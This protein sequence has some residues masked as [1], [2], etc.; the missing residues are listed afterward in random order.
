MKKIAAALAVLACVTLG[1]DATAPSGAPQP[2][3][4]NHWCC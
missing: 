3:A 2:A 4:R 1:A